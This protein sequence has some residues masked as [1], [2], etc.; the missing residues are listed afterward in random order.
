MTSILTKEILE[1]CTT[2]KVWIEATQVS[3]SYK[4]KPPA[5]C[6]TKQTDDGVT[7]F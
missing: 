5:M 4:I 3:R 1:K 6:K 2:L 7:T